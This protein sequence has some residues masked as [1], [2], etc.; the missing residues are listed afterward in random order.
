MRFERGDLLVCQI[1]TYDPRVDGTSLP[2][3]VGE[4]YLCLEWEHNSNQVKIL[5]DNGNAT[6][7]WAGRF[8]RLL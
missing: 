4:K 8:D 1:A 5:D 6:I 3:T 2:L 7:W